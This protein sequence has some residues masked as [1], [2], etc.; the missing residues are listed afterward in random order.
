MALRRAALVACVL[1]LV[2]AGTAAARRVDVF[3]KRAGSRARDGGVSQADQ[4]AAVEILKDFY[5]GV[6]DHYSP[7]SMTRDGV[8]GAECVLVSAVKK[9]K[10]MSYL[11]SVPSTPPG[12]RTTR[13]RGGRSLVR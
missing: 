13:N 11:P 8:R 9:S 10:A 7:A 12:T 1:A 6:F 5:P 3:A 4:V 2:A